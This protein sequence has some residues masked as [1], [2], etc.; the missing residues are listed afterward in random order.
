MA[1][2]VVVG[3]AMLDVVTRPEGPIAPTSDTTSTT[4]VARGGGGAN[5][6]VA[7]AGAGHEV[8]YV[9]AVGDDLAGTLVED[10][11]ARAGV[12]ARL[13]RVAGATGVVVAIVS[14]GA[15]RAMLTDRGVNGRLSAVHVE[16]ILSE[17]FDHL[18]LSGYTLLDPDSRAVGEH[19]LGHARAQGAGSS[20]D[21]CSVAPLARLTAEAFLSSARDARWLFANEEEARLLSRGAE[22]IETLGERFEEVVVTEG[23]RGARSR[24]GT[25]VAHAPSVA[26]RAVD[27]TGAGDAATGAYLAARLHGQGLEESLRAAMAAAAVAVSALGAT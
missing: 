10:S 15:Q 17:G 13:E 12:L 2:V 16:A 19:A 25:L 26:R 9:A 21:A 5:L 14:P 23:E 24:R 18:H 22:P 3:D 11:L 27:T 7:L 20:V 8:H 1:R 6:A 4:R